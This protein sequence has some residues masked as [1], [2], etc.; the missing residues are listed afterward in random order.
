MRSMVGYWALPWAY[1]KER[2]LFLF[3]FN[4]QKGHPSTI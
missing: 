1:L 4:A 2:G 3:F